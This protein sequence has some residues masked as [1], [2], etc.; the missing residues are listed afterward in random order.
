MTLRACLSIALVLCLA[1]P[2]ALR[3]DDLV[4]LSTSLPPNL[5]FVFDTSGSMAHTLW[6]EDYHAQEIDPDDAGA[7]TALHPIDIFWPSTCGVPLAGQSDNSTG[8]CPGSTYLVGSAVDGDTDLTNDPC[9]EADG[10]NYYNDGNVT[11]GCGGIVLPDYNSTDETRWG[12]NYL[13]WLLPRLLDADASNDEYPQDVRADAARDVL[14]DT[15]DSINPN[16]VDDPSDS[17]P[18]YTERVRFGLARYRTDAAGGYVLHGVASGNKA[19]ILSS[20]SSITV[21]GNTP[22]SETLVDVGRYFA[23]TRLLCDLADGTPCYGRYN[24]TTTGATTTTWSSVPQSPVDLS[25][26]KNFVLFTT[27]GKPTEDQHESAYQANFDDIIGNYDLDGNECNPETGPQPKSCIQ[28][29]D[30]G[31]DDGVVYVSTGS[32]YMND[33]AKYLYDYDMSTTLTGTQNVF[34]YTLGFTLDHPLLSET[35][36]AGHGEYFTANSAAGLADQITSAIL[37]I[38]DR[39]SSFTAATVPSSRTTFGDGFY[40]AYF[41]PSSTEPVWQ[42]HLEAYRLSSTGEVLAANGDPA[43]DPATDQFV[44]PRNPFWNAGSV[45]VDPNSPA[46]NLYTTLSGARDAL[47]NAS[48]TDFGL[49]AGDVPLYPNYPTSGV[50][51][52]TELTTALKGYLAG[53]DAFDEDA[54]ADASELREWVLG[55]IFHSNP[56]V[57]GPPAAFLAAEQ[58][59]GKS[60]T[61]EL[62]FRKQWA[63]RDR[64]IYAGA[65][66]GMLHAFHTGD[67]FDGDNADT[68]EVEDGYY[69]LGSGEELFGYV[70]GLLLDDVKYVPRNTNHTRYFVDGSP[71][72]ADAWL[73]D[74]NDPND[75]TK[76]PDEWATVMVTGFRQGGAGY[77]ALDV[78]NPDATTS[79]DPH[80]PYPKLLWEFTHAQLGEAWSEPVIT[81]IKTTGATGSGDKCGGND[82]DGD[83]RE[84]WVAILGA[85][86]DDTGNPNRAGFDSAATVSKGIYMV[87]LDTGALLSSVLYDPNASDARAYMSYSVPSMPA[88]LDLDFDGFADVVY[89]GDLG[90]QLWKWDIHAVGE[91]SD[92][93]SLLDNWTYGR[94]FYAGSTTVAGTPRYRSIYFPVAAS[95]VGNELILAF[96]TG[97]RD[98]LFYAGSATDDENNRFYVIRDDEPTGASAFV[99]SMHTESNLS[100][101][102]GGDSDTVTNDQGFYFKL[103]DSEKFVTNQLVFA[104][105]VIAATYVPDL[106]SS[107]TC[108]R[109]GDARLYVFDVESGL[110]YYFDAGIVTGQGARYTTVGSG[111]PTDPRLSI[112]MTGE[113]LYIQTSTGQVVQV[114]PPDPGSLART[115]Y[116]RH[117][118]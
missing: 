46:R 96:G 14:Y 108:D 92:S 103:V 71:I 5:M 78:T 115:I 36:A 68:S 73:G 111:A 79:S 47:S 8:L 49:V 116:W 45:L 106:S 54:D 102:T 22:L 44:D 15:I 32:D 21:S 72:V 105:F 23:G 88:V 41:E 38:I 95:F 101:I 91:D 107:D 81:R 35:A 74:P 33:V 61:S 94:F 63:E 48:E 62:P 67:W 30:D 25:C 75:V 52:T 93:D 6:H 99:A 77:L 12:W 109:S 87:A 114:D 117:L 37:D 56:S 10:G 58:G 70:P 9:P 43:L 28:D 42:G 4:L 13:N 20:I 60:T 69:D 89:V 113:Q 97:E 1:S 26:R 34:T 64:V 100:D 19:S 11:P 90:G 104:G 2:R 57:V 53:Q 65:N 112:S 118:Y 51:D 98:D 76:T 83:C 82:G 66:D 50:D 17:S 55:D 29:P 39:S 86:Y 3:A 16:V 85:G 84:Q 24:R 40:A 7:L 31:R 59:Y 80:G 110:G 18:A 27:D